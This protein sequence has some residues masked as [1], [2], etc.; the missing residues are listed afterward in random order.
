MLQVFSRLERLKE[1]TPDDL[2]AAE[3]IPLG[4]VC[5]RCNR[6]ATDKNIAGFKFAIRRSWDPLDKEPRA[7]I[8]ALCGPCFEKYRG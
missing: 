6:F 4:P 7:G 3:H 5:N 2:A 8:D 1:V